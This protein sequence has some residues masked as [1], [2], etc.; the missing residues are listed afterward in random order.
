MFQPAAVYYPH[1]AR[2]FLR[3]Y[4]CFQIRTLLS[5]GKI[6]KYEYLTGEKILPS[7]SSQMIVKAKIT[8]S[9]LGK[10][11]KKQTKIAMAQ[12]LRHWIPNTGVSYSKPLSDSKVNS[13]FH[14]SKYDKMSTRNTW[15]PSSKRKNASSQWLCSLETVEPHP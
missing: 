14:P 9:S 15:G 13:A 11:L 12:W 2:T 3:S 5:S 1:Y 10:A 6:D 8:Q 7:G 4:F